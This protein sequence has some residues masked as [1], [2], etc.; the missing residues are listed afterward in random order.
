[1][2]QAEVDRIADDLADRY[3]RW[4]LWRTSDGRYVVSLH[5]EEG[6]SK[7][8]SAETLS[9]VLAAAAE[10][11][12]LPAV[13][14]RPSDPPSLTVAKVEGERTWLVVDSR[15]HFVTR[16]ATKKGGLAFIERSAVRHQQLLIAWEAAY[17]WSRPLREGVD[18]EVVPG[19]KVPDLP[20][21][22]ETDTQPI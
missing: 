3:E 14:P 17:G 2:E 9:G 16:T 21:G 19:L 15:G 12:F 18:Y 5:T 13:A 6:R 10:E 11:T 8:V 1:M 7:Q 4:D 22:S 20:A